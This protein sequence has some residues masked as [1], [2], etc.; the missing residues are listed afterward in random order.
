MY[1]LVL[2]LKPIAPVP[3]FFNVRLVFND[4]KG[5]MYEGS[6]QDVKV[7]FQDL[8]AFAIKAGISQG[9]RERWEESCCLP[10]EFAFYINVGCSVIAKY[11]L[12][13]SGSA[14]AYTM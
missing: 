10:R 4:T 9:N 2:T 12:S 14:K 5:G 7:L 3:T 13:Q 11:G 8:F 6:L 1:S